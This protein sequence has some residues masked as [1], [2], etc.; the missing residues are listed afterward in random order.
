MEPITVSALIAIGTALAA[1]AGSY[2]ASKAV[3]NG[4]KE[5]VE[6]IEAKLDGH[7]TETRAHRDETIQ[8]LSRLE[9]KVD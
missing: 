2:G 7:I 4:T 6:R 1:G 9:T 5:R 3:L 8:R